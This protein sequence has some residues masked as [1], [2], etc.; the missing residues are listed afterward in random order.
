MKGILGGVVGKTITLTG[1]IFLDGGWCYDGKLLQDKFG[2]NV[3]TVNYDKT[4][5][6]QEIHKGIRCVPVCRLWKAA[7]VEAPRLAHYINERENISGVL[8]VL[9]ASQNALR[10]YTEFVRL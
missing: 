9:S 4:W 1:S 8:Y 7:T 6:K 2:Y 10:R 3:Q 5:A